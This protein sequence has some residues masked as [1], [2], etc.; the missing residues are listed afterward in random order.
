MW[1]RTAKA[2]TARLH[3][4]WGKVV[5]WA[6]YKTPEGD[7]FVRQVTLS[8]AAD[9]GRDAV[10]QLTPAEARHLGDLLHIEARK[11]EQM[12]NYQGGWVIDIRKKEDRL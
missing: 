4:H 10:V 8:F 9:D 12:D 6:T 11:V 2:T 3:K 5:S 7:G 1:E